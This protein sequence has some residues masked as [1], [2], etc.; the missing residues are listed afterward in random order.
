MSAEDKILRNFNN[1]NN[2]YIK[3]FN[4]NK[5]RINSNLACKC[6]PFARNII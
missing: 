1:Y 5:I 3:K 4:G 6:K 2:K